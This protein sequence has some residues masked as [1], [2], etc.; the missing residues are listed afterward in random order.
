MH[1]ILQHGNLKRRASLLLLLEDK[2]GNGKGNVFIQLP[3]HHLLHPLCW[4]FV[5]FGL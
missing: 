2:Q 5:S 1:G 3:S 4:S